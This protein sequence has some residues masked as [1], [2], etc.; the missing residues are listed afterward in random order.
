MDSLME[1]L[2]LP[3][4]LP[5]DILAVAIFGLLAV[6]LVILGFK[7]FDWATPKMPI[8]EALMDKNMAVAVTIS[9]VILGICGVVSCVVIGILL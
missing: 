5:G 1:Y 3:E 8:Q 9:A 4:Q 2:H 7:L 6:F